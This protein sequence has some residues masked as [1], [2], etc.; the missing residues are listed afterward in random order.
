MKCMICKEARGTH[1]ICSK[2]VCKGCYDIL[3]A[4]PDGQSE[5]ARRKKG[6]AERDNIARA[7]AARKAALSSV[8]RKA[9]DDRETAAIKRH[10]ARLGTAKA[11]S[12]MWTH[13]SED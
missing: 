7:E 13:A 12:S 6:A 4:T 9:E 3:A 8:E 1:M 2:T 5:I 11:D 10:N